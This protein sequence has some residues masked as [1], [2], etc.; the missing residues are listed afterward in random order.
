M[1]FCKENQFK[2]NLYYLW[3]ESNDWRGAGDVTI[4][5]LLGLPGV[6]GGRISEVELTCMKNYFAINN[7]DEFESPSKI[8]LTSIVF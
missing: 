1:M 6:C 2:I 4:K 8:E 5:P 3:R 7:D